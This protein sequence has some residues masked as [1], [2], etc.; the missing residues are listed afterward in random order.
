MLIIEFLVLLLVLAHFGIAHRRRAEIFPK[1]MGEKEKRLSRHW[2]ATRSSLPQTQNSDCTAIEEG[3]DDSAA[4]DRL[5]LPRSRSRTMN[6]T[7]AA[8]GASILTGL[9]AV[10]LTLRYLGTERYGL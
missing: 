8:Q 9:I 7:D 1:E 5:P 2:G 10:R 3:V 4:I 6:P